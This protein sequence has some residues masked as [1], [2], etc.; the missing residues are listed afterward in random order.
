MTAKDRVV[1]VGILIRDDTHFV[2]VLLVP[3]EFLVVL[4]PVVWIVRY[5]ASCPDLGANSLSAVLI[6]RGMSSLASD[7]FAPG[8]VMRRC[9]YQK[10]LK[11]RKGRI[12][13]FAD[14]EHYQRIVATLTGP[15]RSWSRLTM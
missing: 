10:W 5:N 13:S 14:I 15:L 2:I 6:L 4:L 1:E 3:Q 8:M 12:F 9:I 11:D 7:L